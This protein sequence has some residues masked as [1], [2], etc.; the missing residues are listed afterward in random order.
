MHI[1]VQNQVPSRTCYLVEHTLGDTIDDFA[2]W[3]GFALIHS[4]PPFLK[5]MHVFRKT[6][7]HLTHASL[8]HLTLGPQLDEGVGRNR[9]KS[10]FV[11][12]EALPVPFRAR[13]A[14]YFRSG[15]D[16]GHM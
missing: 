10:V 4:T 7:K 15:Y 12:D 2:T 11:E 6:A 9:S 1:L 14:D 5:L 3:H 16:R 13:L 8:R